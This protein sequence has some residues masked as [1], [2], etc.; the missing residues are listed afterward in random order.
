MQ[1]YSVTFRPVKFLVDEFDELFY[2]KHV[3]DQLGAV[4]DN[5]GLHINVKPN[6]LS[7]LG[8][9]DFTFQLLSVKPV[10]HE[11]TIYEHMNQTLY[12]TWHLAMPLVGNHH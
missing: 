12:P 3:A 1:E 10:I 11:Q 5:L 9:E 6:T 2:Q 7:H 4:W 8:G